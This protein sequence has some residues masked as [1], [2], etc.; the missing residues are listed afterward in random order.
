MLLLHA[1]SC[2]STDTEVNFSHDIIQQKRRF[3][4]ET[5]GTVNYVNID[6]FSSYSSKEYISYCLSLKK[7][8]KYV[9]Y[10]IS[11]LQKVMIV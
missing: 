5:I 10:L 6:L 1:H 4:K 3:I 9:L 8:K 7:V 2:I 11:H